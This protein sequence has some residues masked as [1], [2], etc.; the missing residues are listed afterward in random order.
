MAEISTYLLLIQV[1]I[2]YINA[3]CH[4]FVF[5]ESSTLEMMVQLFSKFIKMFYVQY[6]M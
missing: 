1:G 4:K 6:P 2:S 5:N 3:K